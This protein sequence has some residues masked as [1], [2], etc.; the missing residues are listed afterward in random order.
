VPYRRR[1]KDEKM[2]LTKSIAIGA[3]GNYEEH[4]EFGR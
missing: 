1:E 4:T 3:G 2:G